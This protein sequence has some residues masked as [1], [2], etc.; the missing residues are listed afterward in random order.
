GA[1]PP[2]ELWKAKVGEGSSSPVV[3]DGRVYLMGWNASKDH[4]TCRD[5]GT[6]KEIWHASYECP[7]YGRRST[8][9]E[10]LYSGPTSTPEFDPATGLI[11]TLSC[12]GDLQ[13]WN[14]RAQGQRVW[15]VNL[16]ARFDVPQRP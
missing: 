14:A 2:R 16:S 12:D 10:G 7:R 3:V 6:G 13:C 15:S 4:V 11:Y 1:W 8:G 9:D 5:A